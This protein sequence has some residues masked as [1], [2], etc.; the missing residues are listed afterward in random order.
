MGCDY[1][2][3]VVVEGLEDG[4]VRPAKGGEVAE[5]VCDIGIA[6]FVESSYLY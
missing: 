6:V 4:V 1:E 3:G 5:F 2:P